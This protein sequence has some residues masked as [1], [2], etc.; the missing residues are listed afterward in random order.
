MTWT[1]RKKYITKGAKAY[2]SL[3]LIKEK[4]L[5]QIRITPGGGGGANYKGDANLKFGHF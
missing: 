3:L 5:Y 2:T 1:R 4:P